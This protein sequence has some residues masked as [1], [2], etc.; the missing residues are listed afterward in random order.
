MKEHRSAWLELKN[1]EVWQNNHKLVDG[2]SMNLD[3][4]VP[5]TVLGP[6]GSG[7]ST[8]IKLI[9]RR[10]HPVVKTNSQIRL[11][12][13]EFI[14]LQELRQRIGILNSELDERIP[15]RCS[16]REVLLSSCFGSTRLGIG[17]SP[18]AQQHNQ[19]TSLLERFE[20][21]DLE[22][23][24]Y[25]QLSDGQKR[26]LLITKALIHKPEVLVL[27]EPARALDLR[28]YHQLLGIIREL[29]KDGITVVQATHRVETIVPEMKELVFLKN[30][31]VISQGSPMTMLTENKL[32]SLFNT[33]LKIV[34]ANGYR[35]VVP[36]ATQ[37]ANR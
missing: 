21:S 7:K 2:H 14:H 19:V 10:L 8:L 27:D 28:A 20:L 12:G 35:Q 4:G 11:F 29:C 16:S 24:E 17:Q 31:K 6:N 23:R 26:R 32:S 36:G 37:S 9:E 15:A 1:I 25:R 30:G 5:T 13:Q 18:T 22:T 33:D 34:E 3:L